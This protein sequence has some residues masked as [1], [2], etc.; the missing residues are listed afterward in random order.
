MFRRCH[1]VCM[2]SSRLNPSSSSKSATLASSVGQ[3][4][5]G[6]R[7]ARERRSTWRGWPR[8]RW[9]GT[10]TDS[11]SLERLL[12]P[13]NCRPRA[14]QRRLGSPESGCDMR[15]LHRSDRPFRP[16]PTLLTSALSLIQTPRT[17]RSHLYSTTVRLLYFLSY[18]HVSDVKPLHSKISEIFYLMEHRFSSPTSRV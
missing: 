7:R 4:D 2:P 17:A 16:Y 13:V 1:L 3:A 10:R 18:I 14:P 9:R 6:G 8:P 11:A 12:S 5:D 15:R